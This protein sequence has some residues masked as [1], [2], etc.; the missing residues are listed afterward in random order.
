MIIQKYPIAPAQNTDAN[1]TTQNIKVPVSGV[2]KTFINI[3]TS[4]NIKR[5][6][7]NPVTDPRIKSNGTKSLNP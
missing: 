3:F 2:I 5:Q 1:T 4:L 7:V 6:N